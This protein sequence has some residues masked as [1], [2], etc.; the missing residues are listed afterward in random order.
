MYS[1]QLSTKNLSRESI[2]TR[3]QS[4]W[5]KNIDDY[6]NDLTKKVMFKLDLI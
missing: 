2:S 4:T 6:K 3:L 5:N 1:S